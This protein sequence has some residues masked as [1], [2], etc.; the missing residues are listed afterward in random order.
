MLVQR[1]SRKYTSLRAVIFVVCSVPKES[2]IDTNKLVPRMYVCIFIKLH[3]TAQS[4]SVILVILCHSHR[5]CMYVCMYVCILYIYIY[6]CMV[7]TW[8]SAE[9]GSTWHGYQSCSWWAEQGKRFFS[10]SPFA[11]DNFILARRVRP[12]P[13]PRHSPQPSWNNFLPWYVLSKV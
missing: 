11:P 7:G 4:G 2:T 8:L 6:V 5:S 3:I 12:W 13:A 10:L 9:H 1:T